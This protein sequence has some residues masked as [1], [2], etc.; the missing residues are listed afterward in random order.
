MTSYISCTRPDTYLYSLLSSLLLSL[1]WVLCS[2]QSACHNACWD[3]PTTG[4]MCPHWI[5]RIPSQIG[6]CSG[7][8]ENGGDGTDQVH[9]WGHEVAKRSGITQN[10][11]P[12][13]SAHCSSANS[14]S[15]WAA[16][17][18]MAL[19][20]GGGSGMVGIPGLWV[21]IFSAWAGTADMTVGG[22]DEWFHDGSQKL[23]GSGC[24]AWWQS[25]LASSPGFPYIIFLHFKTMTLFMCV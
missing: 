6:A 13:L 21:L 23:H 5:A 19:V 15:F 3:A 1:S 2:S 4:T 18:R 10:Y 7:Y 17:S 25:A 22:L 9:G 16:W 12:S 20:S 8:L 24:W 11:E 14:K